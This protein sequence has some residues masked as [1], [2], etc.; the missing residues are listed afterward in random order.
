M[1]ENITKKD[2]TL[3]VSIII[4]AV[5]IAGA[6]VYSADLKSSLP[7]RSSS[8]TAA[9]LLER[10]APAQGLKLSATWG[11]LGQKLTE[12]G[13]LDGQKFE[14]ILAS[15]GELTDEAKK[16]LYDAD[17][18][19]IK[20]TLGNAGLWLNLFWALGLANKNDILEKGPMSNPA[21]GGADRFA[22]TG[23]WTIA[24]GNVMDHFSQH[25]F[26]KLTEEQQKKAAEAAQNIYRP[27]CNNPTH[28]P[29]CNH[30]MAMLGLLEL[31][32]AQD[33]NLKDMYTAALAVNSYWFP[34]QYLTIAKYLNTNNIKIGEVSPEKIL[35][36]NFS[37]ASGF[38]QVK[39]KISGP[40]T[41]NK[42]ACG[43]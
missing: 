26:L 5:L 9:S 4:S 7:P 25:D 42:G 15:R 43:V 37:S 21:Y 16:L 35:A 29:D 11:D 13:V 31:M 18:G 24:Q 23:G 6:W 2:Y 39:N 28:F 40:E 17:N 41:E 30:G 22:S 8:K 38:E 34:D 14:Q 33:A 20:I 36:G 3:P 10:V 32:A 12:T 1:E 27:C 19:Q